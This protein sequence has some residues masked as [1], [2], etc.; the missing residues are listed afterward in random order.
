MPFP[1]LVPTLI[2][3]LSFLNMTIGISLLIDRRLQSNM[4]GLEKGRFQDGVIMALVGLLSTVTFQVV[5]FYL[6]PRLGW[7]DGSFATNANSTPF[8][9]VRASFL[10]LSG[11]LGFVIGYVVPSGAAAYL[12]QASSMRLNLQGGRLPHVLSHAARLSPH[13]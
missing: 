1:I 13:V 11:S 4:R 7:I 8:L 9:L 3:S 10:V 6:A 2:S 12:Q 5:V